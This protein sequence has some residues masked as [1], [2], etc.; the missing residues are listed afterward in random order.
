LHQHS[1]E[2]ST[3]NGSPLSAQPRARPI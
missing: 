3:A 2:P 1:T